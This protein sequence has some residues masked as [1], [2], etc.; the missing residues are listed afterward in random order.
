M[1]RK[2]LSIGCCLVILLSG[3][4]ATPETDSTEK[5]PTQ[6]TI[7]N[8]ETLSVTDIPP[9]TDSPSV[10]IHQN[11]PTFSTYEVQEAT[12]SYE[13]YS[14]LDDLGRCQSAQASIGQDLMPTEERESLGS[15]TPS[16]WENAQY[17][18]VDGSWLYNR[19]HLIGFQLAGEQANALN[20]ITGTRYMN[21]EGMLPYENQIAEYVKS[22]GNHV[23]Y[24]VTPIYKDDNLLAS[25]VQLEAYSVED[26]GKGIQFNVY[27]YNVQPGVQIDY[28]TGETQ[29]TA[30]CTLLDATTEPSEATSD[31]QVQTVYVSKT[32]TK[33]HATP[34]CS[35]MKHPV[36]LSIEDAQAQGYEPC[37]KC[38][39]KE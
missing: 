20:L 2:W 39:S 9:Y 31:P 12:T 17:S 25:G 35:K 23:L 24:E 7:S 11:I 16:G 14:E 8:E 34:H 38:W 15:V 30:A 13:T 33:Y 28:A 5:S 26:Q 37:K 1:Q 36:A 27:C 6:E 22:T 19:S 3:C 32:G 29:G 10:E 18:C 21:V 4:S